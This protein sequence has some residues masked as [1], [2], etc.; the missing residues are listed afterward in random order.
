[1]E[2]A[3]A[4][5]SPVPLTLEESLL[6]LSLVEQHDEEDEGLELDELDEFRFNVQNH[7]QAWPPQ[8]LLDMEDHLSRSFDLPT[9]W[10]FEARDKANH[11]AAHA[12]EPVILASIPEYP[13]NWSQWQI[14]SARSRSAM[15]H[16]KLHTPR[17]DDEASSIVGS[18]L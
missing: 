1:V 17:K 10:F 11:A 16:R 7:Q 8:T 3:P 12:R 6:D 18:G 2:I 14:E 13:P 4:V 5:E 9:F 15:R